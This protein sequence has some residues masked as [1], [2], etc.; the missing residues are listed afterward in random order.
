MPPTK[1]AYSANG[2]TST[3]QASLVSGNS[4]QTALSSTS[5]RRVN[6]PGAN[7]IA[8]V[9]TS[10]TSTTASRETVNSTIA[11]DG[12]IATAS[13]ASTRY[14]ALSHGTSSRS[15]AAASRMNN[16]IP[17]NCCDRGSSPKTENDNDVSV[18][19]NGGCTPVPTRSAIRPLSP[20]RWNTI[21]SR[22]EIIASM[23]GAS[24]TKRPSCTANHASTAPTAANVVPDH[25]W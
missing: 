20:S 14:P 25:N 3:R 6:S 24:P 11:S 10:S 17:M 19:I 21:D 1:N 13:A 22:S 4:A 9:T 5:R 7:A 12:V 16:A 2:P 8:S 23:S 15:V 18:S